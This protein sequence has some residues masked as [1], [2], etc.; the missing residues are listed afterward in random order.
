MNKKNLTVFVVG[1]LI[2]AAAMVF[3]YNGNKPI[4]TDLEI[5]QDRNGTKR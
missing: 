5:C 3:F 1:L 4:T 2:A